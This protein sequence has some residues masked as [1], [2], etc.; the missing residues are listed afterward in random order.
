MRLVNLKW[1]KELPGKQ[2]QLLHLNLS[3]MT[4]ALAGIWSNFL[5]GSCLLI[6]YPILIPTKIN[7]QDTLCVNQKKNS[8]NES[9][10]RQLRH[11]DD[12]R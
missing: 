5:S 12:S 10:Q 7:L 6:V 3:R 9:Y 2:T 1:M 4:S 11:G 8:Q